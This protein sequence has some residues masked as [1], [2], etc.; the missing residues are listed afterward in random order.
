M[1][2]GDRRVLALFPHGCP[3]KAAETAATS[4]AGTEGVPRSI[5]VIRVMT[6]PPRMAAASSEPLK[7]RSAMCTP[8]SSAVDRRSGAAATMSPPITQPKARLAARVP[9]QSRSRARTLA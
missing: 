4:L 5:H 3:M 1:I 6:V 9:A 8:F 7:P 2:P